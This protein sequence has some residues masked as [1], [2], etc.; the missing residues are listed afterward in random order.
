LRVGS[1]CEHEKM[2]FSV[3]QDFA[4]MSPGA[5]ILALIIFGSECRTKSVLSLCW[6]RLSRQNTNPSS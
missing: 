2:A 5:E 3:D 4:E 6:Q 1:Q